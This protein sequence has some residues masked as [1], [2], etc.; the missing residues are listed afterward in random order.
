[1]EPLGRQRSIQVA[2]LAFETFASMPITGPIDILNKSS[3][4]WNGIYGKALPYGSFNVEL[5][6]LT[7]RP[8]KFGDNIT[9]CPHASVLTATKPDLILIPSVGEN[10]LEKLPSLLPFIPWIKQCSMQGARVASLC[11]GA[12]LLAET[13]LLDGRA[14][15]THWFLA[16]LFRKNY[17]KV[18]VHPE[19][20]I[21][22]EGL[23][24]TSGAAT[25]FLDLMLYLIQLYKGY[26][27][28]VLVA[29]AFLIEM[30][31]NTQLHYAT[32]SLHTLHSDREILRVQQFIESNL[33][34]QLTIETMAQHADMS[35]RNFD[36]RFRNAVG[37]TPSSYLQKRRIEKAK[38][39]LES[40]NDSIEEIMVHVGY[41]D[42]RSFR[43][44]FRSLTDLSPKAYRVRYGLRRPVHAV[45][46]AFSSTDTAR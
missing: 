9:I 18:R 40:T 30:G 7:K 12:F 20:L 11:T 29:K 37:E 3:A 31:R 28:A 33:G 10:V 38:R 1:M 13:G 15:T 26:E 17:P 4:V 32:P 39:L 14:A 36:R 25:S 6:S 44:L 27:A 23:V 22:D 21:V 35:V 2:V 19:R 41:E 45:S 43:R 46:L 34:R 42:D 5:V 16:D 8:I 24:I